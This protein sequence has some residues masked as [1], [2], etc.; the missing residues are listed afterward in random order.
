MPIMA[1]K[2]FT[3]KEPAVIK[4]GNI[5]DELYSTKRDPVTVTSELFNRCPEFFDL[6]YRN[7]T[8]ESHGEISQVYV[9]YAVGAVQWGRIYSKY[10]LIDFTLRVKDSDGGISQRSNVYIAVYNVIRRFLHYKK[11]TSTFMGYVLK[12]V[13]MEFARYNPALFSA[14]TSKYEFVP[15]TEDISAVEQNSEIFN[16]TDNFLNANRLVYYGLHLILYHDLFYKETARY[17]SYLERNEIDD[18]IRKIKQ[19]QNKYSQE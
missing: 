9:M 1:T 2:S 16:L 13:M 3:Y 12:Y 6:L 7:F 14:Y 10:D 17:L 19:L 4:A 8:F 18:L 15:F 5:L 11:P